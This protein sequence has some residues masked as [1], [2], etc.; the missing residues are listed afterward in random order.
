MARTKKTTKQPKAIASTQS[1]S[2]FVKSICDVMRRSNCASALQ[3]VP[4]LTW[5][6]FLRILDAQEAKAR[7]EAEVLGTNFTP[8]LNSPYRWQDWAA[9]FSEKPEHPKTAEGKPFGWKRQEL[10][11]AG[12][13]KL[14]DFI[15]KEL[16][17][18]LH[19]LDVDPQT[20]LPNPGASR[21]Q[22]IMG[23]TMTAVERVRVDSEANLRDILDKVHE[24]NID[25]VDDQHFF[26]LSQVYED[27]LLKMG[28]K[29]SDGGQFF[30][31]RE[32]IRA[33]V[34]TV[35]PQL[36][37]TVY[38]PCCGTGGFL[39][40]AYEHIARQVGPKPYQYRPGHLKT[41]Y[42]FWPRK[43]EPSIPHRASQPGAA[44]HRPAQP[45]AR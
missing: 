37:Q 36:G 21:K 38:D 12:D 15:N 31:P 25:H 13:G 19:S 32:V 41:R 35:K 2:S 45:V 24:I 44:W 14:F 6:L 4:E 1:L 16:L 39:A 17:P 7:E 33:M 27:L 43:G 23:R 42:F 18:H 8:A 29:N 30:T 5:I 34:H 26:T 28:E 10:F 20:G 40:I 9:P 11:A 22:R 3:Y